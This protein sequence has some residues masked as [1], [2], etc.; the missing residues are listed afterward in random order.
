MLPSVWLPIAE[1]TMDLDKDLIGLC[2]TGFDVR[3][4]QYEQLYSRL[5]MS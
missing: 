3:C 5:Y 1:K 4:M 2:C